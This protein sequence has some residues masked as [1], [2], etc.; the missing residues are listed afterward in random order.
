MADTKLA[1]NV[2]EKQQ[3]FLES[4]AT[5]TL[6]G[7]AAGGGKSFA[8][9]IDALLYAMRYAGSSQL[10]MRRTFPELERSLIRA[11][12]ELYPRSAYSYNGGKHIMTFK[13]GSIIEFGY[14]DAEKDA[15]KYQSAEYDRIFFDEL[16]HFSEWIYTYIRSRCRGAND[17]PKQTKAGT[18]PGSEGHAWV[19]DRF[20]D[21]GEAGKIHEFPNGTR[22][23]IQAKV[24]DNLFLMAKDPDYIK[25]LQDLPDRERRALL[26]GDWD[27][28]EGQYFPEFNRQIH[29][30][31]PFEI[32]KHWK[33]F[34]TMDYGLDML[35]CYWIAVDE[36]LRGYIIRELYEPNLII[37]EAA[38]RIK[39]HGKV[40][41]TLGPPDMWN[42]RQETG[43]S[44][45]DIF[46]ENGIALTKTS[47]DRISG[48]MAVKEWLNPFTDEQ[49]I[50]RAKIGIFPSC[51]NLIRSIPLLQ[52][53]E[54]KPN[55]VAVN[56]HEITHGP[57]A[58][59]GFCV[60]WTTATSPTQ[61][62]AK[63]N[64]TPDM[65]E[66]YEQARPEDKKTLEKMWGAG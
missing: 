10:I 44:V 55:D 22:L 47:N 58:L 42:R 27:I 39:A 35:A 26:D 41:M 30:V 63:R 65:W 34:R 19:K 56:P 52:H 57:D 8:I 14:C 66:D 3:A 29:V 12:L 50:E 45:A 40:Y 51:V 28:F 5:E 20:I 43:R 23:F 16:T 2:T 36:Q 17:F 9:L 24:Q 61:S 37:S 62:K 18:N 38:K 21:I 59:R 64:W 6:Y 48:W 25:R 33:I 32:P 1:L 31:K 15:Y 49:G 11:A 13:N 53:D 7:G 46:W 60:Y 54:K 4:T